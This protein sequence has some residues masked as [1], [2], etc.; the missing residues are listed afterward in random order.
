MC[1]LESFKIDLKGLKDS[2]A[3]FC[4][5]LNDDYFKA[6]DGPEVRSGAVRVTVS[7]TKT[8]GVYELDFHTEGTV[9]IQ[10]DICLDDMQQPVCADNRLLARLGEEYSEDDDII[11]VEKDEG[12]LDVSWLIYEFI[13]L[14]LPVRHAHA[15][16]ECNPEMIRIL[17]E[18]SAGS[19]AEGEQKP[20]VDPR[21]SE[22]EKLKTIIKD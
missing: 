6:V 13:A 12:L 14:S 17:E 16:G 19:G 9:N 5:D 10:C 8:A 1:G 11:T 2:S 4:Y 3:T 18:H 21:W 15:P 22:L 20:A 7:V